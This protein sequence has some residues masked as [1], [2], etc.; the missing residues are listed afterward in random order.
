MYL[1][2]NA[3]RNIVRNKGKH[4]LLGMIALVIGLASCVALSIRQAAVKEKQDGLDA[5]TITASIE[6]D[7][8]SMMENMTPPDEADSS[9]SG[10]DIDDK[11][12]MFANMEG[13]SLEELKTY[14]EASSVKEFY[15]T[16]TLSLNGSGVNAIST[17]T[18]SN[19]NQKMPQGMSM[20]SQSDFSLI[21]YSSFTAMSAFSDGTASIIEGTV[22]EENSTNACMINEE[23]AEYN[24]LAVGDT[25]TLV[26]PDQE[27]DTFTL[28]IIG[29]YSSTESTS[30]AMGRGMSM[31]DPAN[32]IYT[33][34]A[35]VDAITTSSATATSSDSDTVLNATV[36]GT[37]VFADVSDYEAFEEEAQELGLS[38]DYS[39]TSQDVAAYEQG[40]APLESLSSYAMIFLGVVLVI[41]GVVLVVLHIYHIRER[42]YEIG[43]LAA[44]GMNKKKVAIQFVCEIFVVTMISVLI[45]T[46]IGAVCSV[47]ITNT[48]LVNTSVSSSSKMEGMG[49]GG[50]ESADG[51]KDEAP[52]GMM[53]KSQQYLQEIS[54][55]T[56]GIV[57]LQVCG[58][59]LLLVVLSSGIAVMSILRYEPLKILSNRE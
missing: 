27:E 40:I 23:L 54:S 12:D 48:L 18:S 45:G 24:D 19:S 57:V 17:S 36:N 53:Q 8:M 52:S 20:G 7:R 15:Y 1:M 43:V 30:N 58:V 4:L 11:K 38:D 34:A 59:A 31:M 21:G 28:T 13:L 37:Y 14:A 3:L 29:I 9:N 44:I 35:A 16:Q 25:I 51:E 6:V 33:T 50:M 47:P 2:K 55:A 46:G 5:L 42:K 56:D 22:F 41:G 10:G 49:K 39:V 26:N 32:Q